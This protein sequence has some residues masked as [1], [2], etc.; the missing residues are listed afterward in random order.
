MSKHRQGRAALRQGPIGIQMLNPSCLTRPSGWFW[1]CLMQVCC[2]C[3]GGAS[4][5]LV[6][7]SA[8]SGSCR[9]VVPHLL[10]AIHTRWN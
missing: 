1:P 8:D 2:A 10:R 3:I 5:L 9:H 4:L 6:L 7:N